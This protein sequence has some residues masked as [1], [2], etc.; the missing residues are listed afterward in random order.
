MEAN[1]GAGSV[2]KPSTEDGLCQRL[3]EQ[4]QMDRVQ[5]VVAAGEAYLTWAIFVGPKEERLPA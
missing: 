2:V 1:L 3:Q 4:L 5:A